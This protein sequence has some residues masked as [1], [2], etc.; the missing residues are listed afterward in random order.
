MQHERTELLE[1]EATPSSTG[2]GPA[3]SPPQP[4]ALLTAP[5][6]T[7]RGAAVPTGELPPQDVRPIAEL[8]AEA[9]TLRAR[10][11]ETAIEIFTPRHLTA[12]ELARHLEPQL[13]AGVG[14]LRSTEDASGRAGVG[15]HAARPA[16]VV[17]DTPS[18]LTRLRRLADEVDIPQARSAST[19]RATLVTAGATPQ[20]TAVAGSPTAGTGRAERQSLVLDV[21]AVAIRVSPNRPA[22]VDLTQL[23]KR[24]AGF[25]LHSLQESTRRGEVRLASAGETGDDPALSLG[26]LTGSQQRLL[27]ELRI[28]GPVSVVARSRVTLKDGQATRLSVEEPTG[29]NQE[30]NRS[31]C[32]GMRPRLQNDGSLLLQLLD[33]NQPAEAGREPLAELRVAGGETAVL[34]G[35]RSNRPTT[36]RDPRAAGGARVAS[37]PVEWVYLVTPR[38]PEAR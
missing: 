20:A 22:G 14:D 19:N 35:M 32:V 30:L 12:S 28:N 37:Q 2:T 11:A 27:Q 31:S 25:E 9:A 8:D 36:V 16:V 24:R 29:D 38:L 23:S 26:V 4:A 17:R 3:L 7:A 6:R 21:T 10:Q 5:E 15:N 1:D 18:N 34:A 33:C 13:T